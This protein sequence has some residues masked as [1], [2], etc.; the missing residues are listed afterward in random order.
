MFTRTAAK[1]EY[2]RCTWLGAQVFA[3]ERDERD[4]LVQVGQRDSTTGLISLSQSHDLEAQVANSL[5]QVSNPAHTCI[6]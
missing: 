4:E 1:H 3:A 6:S 2:N 5:E